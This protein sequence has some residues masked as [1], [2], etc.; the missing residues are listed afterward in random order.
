VTKSYIWSIQRDDGS[1]IVNLTAEVEKV[2]SVTGAVVQGRPAIVRDGQAVIEAMNHEP[3][4][5]GLWLC[6]WNS[7]DKLGKVI[8]KRI[9]DAS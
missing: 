7:G 4:S 1:E 9:R 6:R 2:S 5:T 3:Q 8:R